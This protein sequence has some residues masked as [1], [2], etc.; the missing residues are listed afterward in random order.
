MSG[1][2]YEQKLTAEPVDRWALS[3]FPLQTVGGGGL[4][5]LVHGEC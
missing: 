5:H 3:G 2:A 1:L 4:R